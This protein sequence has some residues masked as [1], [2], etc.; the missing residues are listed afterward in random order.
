MNK[1][2]IKI[3]TLKLKCQVIKFTNTSKIVLGLSPDLDTSVYT[4]P[5]QDTFQ[6]PE[7]H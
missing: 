5:S 1:V 6:S 3:T 2:T 7:H 4:I